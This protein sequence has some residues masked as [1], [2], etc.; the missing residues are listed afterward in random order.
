MMCVTIGADLS[1]ERVFAG[2]GCMRI[3]GIHSARTMI[4]EERSVTRYLESLHED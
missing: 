4:E 2:G 3:F 1:P